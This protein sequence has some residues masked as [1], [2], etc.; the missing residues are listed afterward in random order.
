M[1]EEETTL[2]VP[3]IR[4]A[5]LSKSQQESEDTDIFMSKASEL[6]GLGRNAKRRAER[7]LQKRHAG[8]EGAESKKIDK[9]STTAYNYLDLVLPPYNLDYLAQL[10]DINPAHHTAI[11]IVASNVVGLGLNLVESEKTKTKL[12]SKANKEEREK[13]RTKIQ[14]ARVNLAEYIDSLNQEDSLD[15]VLYKVFVD[16]KAMGMGYLEIG[17]VDTPDENGYR[18]IGYIGHVPAQTVRVRR[19]RDGFVQLGNDAKVVYFRHFG[20]DN[21]NKVTD[22]PNPNELIC[23]SKYSPS[24]S[25]YGVPEIVS[26]KNAVAGSEFAARYNLDYFEN[27]AVPRH[28]IVLKSNQQVGQAHQEKILQFFETGLKGQNHRSLFIPL[29]A[30]TDNAKTSLDIKPIEAG[31]VDLSFD[32]YEKVNEGKIFMVHRVPRSK[33]SSDGTGSQ[34][35]ALEAARTFKSEVITPEQKKFAKKINMVLREFTDVFVWEFIEQSLVDANM[36]S[37][38]DDRDIKNGSTTVNEVRARRGQSSLPWGDEKFELKP[39]EKANQRANAAQS[40]ERDTQRDQ[41]A[42]QT[43]AEGKNPNGEGRRYE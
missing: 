25:Y 15:E 40:R 18:R 36:Q 32:K 20:A 23:F 43:Q 34:Q 13:F 41:G 7:Q 39:Q 16:Y 27:K 14:R 42:A 30:D 6:N 21:P 4:V 38:I 22:D 37:S 12:D 28:L 19:N 11:H 8:I 10:P 5:R 33:A 2:E 31:E 24:N 17:R 26:A 35:V 1:A 3:E 9:E 29:P